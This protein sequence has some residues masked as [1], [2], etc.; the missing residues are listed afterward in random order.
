MAWSDPADASLALLP[1]EAR[2]G[3]VGWVLRSMDEK[4]G[5]AKDDDSDGGLHTVL[6]PATAA[7]PSS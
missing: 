3:L 1:V 2:A 7:A 4:K 6:L 5:G